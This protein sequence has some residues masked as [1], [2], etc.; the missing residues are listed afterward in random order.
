MSTLKPLAVLSFGA[1]LVASGVACAPA[2]ESTPAADGTHAE[3]DSLGASQRSYVVISRDFRKCSYPMCGGYFVHD[4]NRKSKK[5]TYVAALDFSGSDLDEANADLVAGAPAGEVVL[6]GKLGKLD[7]F[8]GMKTFRVEQAWRG[9]PGEVVDESA[10]LFYATAALDPQPQCFVAPC[11]AVSAKVLHKSD[12]VLVEGID[13]EG[14]AEPLLDRAWLAGRALHQGALVAGSIVEGEVFQ[15][16]PEHLLA[17]SQVF[18]RL[19]EEQGACPQ[20]RPGCPDGQVATYTRDENRCVVLSGCAEP[21]ACAAY[22][23]A[24]GEGYDLVSWTGGMFACTVYGC[25]PSWVAPSED[26][27]AASGDDAAEDGGAEG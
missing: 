18:L 7:G 5:E 22:V 12:E 9:M 20:S 13:L 17:A 21:G 6:Y 15:G 19:P 16:G 10:E 27:D 2:S 4:V 25:D 1:L 26:A 23:P 11:P 8:D 14:L 3:E 24:C